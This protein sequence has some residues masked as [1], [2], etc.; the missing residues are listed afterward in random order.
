[1]AWRDTATYLGFSWHAAESGPPGFLESA[2][3]ALS[4]AKHSRQSSIDWSQQRDLADGGFLVWGHEVTYAAAHAWFVRLF[5]N[6]TN[7][8]EGK[9]AQAKKAKA[10]AHG[11][12]PLTWVM[13]P[14]AGPPCPAS[15]PDCEPAP[16]DEA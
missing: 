16:G 14:P 13:V 9:K 8:K 10:K 5:K 6:V 15:E 3:Q 2:R 1:M 7:A 11:R 12:T 4:E